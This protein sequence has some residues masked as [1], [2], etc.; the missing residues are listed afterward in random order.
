M[1]CNWGI[2]G[3]KPAQAPCAFPQRATEL[4]ETHLEFWTVLPRVAYDTE[5]SLRYT[6]HGC[7]IK[8]H[9]VIITSQGCSVC[10][11]L[12]PSFLQLVAAAWAMALTAISMLKIV[13]T[14]A[15]LL[16]ECRALA[17][18][19]LSLVFSC[20]K[21][22]R[23]KGLL[24]S[25][26]SSAAANVFKYSL[27]YVKGLLLNWKPTTYPMSSMERLPLTVEA[28]DDQPSLASHNLLIDLLLPLVFTVWLLSSW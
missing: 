10:S 25:K 13:S 1:F 3:S 6:V 20:R 7:T 5:L 14:R 23:M 19:L 11:A 2:W 22:S 18:S 27:K 28:E 4:V 8:Q 21:Y 12:Q 9:T 15:P 26:F 17:L 24:A 16:R